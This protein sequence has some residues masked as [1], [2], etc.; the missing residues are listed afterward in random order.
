MVQRTEETKPE[1]NPP[2]P[3]EGPERIVPE[4]PPDKDAPER[5]ILHREGIDV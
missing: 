4:I 3:E 5:K 2:T 1:I